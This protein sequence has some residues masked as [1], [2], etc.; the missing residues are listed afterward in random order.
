MSCF[1]WMCLGTTS[2]EACVLDLYTGW[3]NQL[4]FEE[5]KHSWKW[6]TK[7]QPSPAPQKRRFFAFQNKL[8]FTHGITV[9]FHGRER[10]DGQHQLKQVAFGWTMLKHCESFMACLWIPRWVLAIVGDNNLGYQTP[11][12]EW[13]AA[14][15]K[16]KCQ[17]SSW[18][19]CSK[20][21][22]PFPD[23]GFGKFQH[24]FWRY[25]DKWFK[26]IYIY[27]YKYIII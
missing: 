19:K 3:F 1:V 12:M 26:Y 18:E 7:V 21:G 14:R 17:D 9:W 15:W 2:C 25:I 27:I 22:G 11:P 4:L 10:V 16:R 5:K 23:S 13:E 6:K 8:I 20:Q 24:M